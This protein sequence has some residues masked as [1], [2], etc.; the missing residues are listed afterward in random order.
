MFVS[1]AFLFGIAAQFRAA[2]GHSFLRWMISVIEGRFGIVYAV[3]LATT[4]FSPFILNDVLILVLTPVLASYAK[5][6]GADI[7]PMLVAEVTFA[8]I[9][10]SLTPMGN[11]QN[12]LLWQASRIP[13]VSFVEGTWTPLALSGVIAGIL[14]LPM[15]GTRARAESAPPPGPRSLSAGVYLA[16]AA[17]AVFLLDS[18]GVSSVLSLGAAF[19]L[20]FCFTFRS[21]R[22]VPREFD[23]KSLLVLCLLVG[24]V[25]ILASRFEPLLSSYGVAAGSGGQPYTSAFFALVSAAIS[26]VPATQLVLST[27]TVAPHAAP[28]IAVDAGLAGN[29]CPLSSLANLLALLMVRRSGLP[30]RRAVALQ[31]GIGLVAFLPAIL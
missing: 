16:G 9:A 22:Q 11:P 20:G 3:V 28:I 23:I 7:S 30:V 12:I 25:A 8:N 15:R 26:N 21:L 29:I 17:A 27:A 18:I 19:A 10:G 1:F 4:I 2:D 5:Q 6:T 14:L 13:A 31:L 24:T